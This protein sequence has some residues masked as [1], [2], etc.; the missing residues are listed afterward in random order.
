LR[1]GA[2]L[3]LTALLAAGCGKAGP[4]VHKVSG[5]LTKGGQPLQVAG[6]EARIGLVQLKFF[7]IDDQGQ[8]GAE[9][10]DATADAN[11]NFTVMGPD[12]KG[13]PPGKYRVAVFQFDP[14]PQDK[15]KGAFNEKKSRIVRDVSGA[16]ELNIDLDKP[17]E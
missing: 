12:G 3:L 10:W 8:I 14:Y 15:L 1:R 16:T 9:S 6:Q 5:R 2:A 11:G 17:N 13:L 7:R 4:V